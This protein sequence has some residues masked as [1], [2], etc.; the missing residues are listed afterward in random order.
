VGRGAKGFAGAPRNGRANAQ[1]IGLRQENVICPS[2]IAGHFVEI[3]EM[4]RV[5]SQ[6]ILR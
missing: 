4:V 1:G 2:R 3:N 6:T 5:W